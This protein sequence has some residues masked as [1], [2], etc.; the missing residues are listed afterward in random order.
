[1]TT[2][3]WFDEAFEVLTGFS[4]MGW[5]RRLFQ[6]HFL[7]G[8]IPAACDLPTGLGK[9]SVMAIWVLALARQAS[10]SRR[11]GLPRRLVYV[12]N[13]RTVV[14]Q[15]SSEAGALRTALHAPG[16]GGVLGAVRDALISLCV[17][18]EDEASPLAIST[19]RGQLADNAEWRADPARPAIIIGTVD[20]IGSRLLFS[21]YGRGFKSRP[22]HAG[23][24][25]QDALLVHDEAHLEPAFQTLVT[26]VQA[27]QRRCADSRKLRVMALTAT[28]RDSGGVTFGLAAEDFLERTVRERVY[29]RKG[30][31]FH[32]VNNEKAIAATVAKLALG[33]ADGGQ[34]V[35][36]YLRR[37]DDVVAVVE[38]LREEGQQVQALTGTLRGLERDRLAT[39]DAVFAR[40]VPKPNVALASGTVFLV[41]T[42]AGE[43]GAN[44]S[45][46][47]LVCDA[48]TLEA[49]A[50]RFGRVNRFGRGDARIDLVFAES[51]SGAK[52]LED[53]QVAAEES[54]APAED[55]AGRKGKEK[56]P[57]VFDEACTQAVQAL[58]R[59]PKREDGL[60][61]GSPAALLD[62]LK[63]MSPAQRKAAFLPVPVILQATD[64]LFDTWA[65][66]TIRDRLPGRP[67]VADWLHG[68][69][70][71]EP[72]ETYVAWREEVGLITGELLE[73]YQPADL[74]D[75]YPLKPHELLR[76]R[77]DRV[78]EHLEVIAARCPESPVW[79]IDAEDRVTVH[80]LADLAEK[81]KRHR[82][83]IPL[84]NCTV[85]L[86]P[87]SGGLRGGMLRGEATA[88]ECP[89]IDV[90]DALDDPNGRQMRSRVWD[91]TTVPAGMRTVR[92]IDVRRVGDEEMAVAEEGHVRRY[93]RWCVC[94]RA[95]DDDGSQHAR[96]AEELMPHVEAVEHFANLFVEKLGLNEPEASAL[97]VAAH[98]H[99]RGKGRAVWQRS[100][101]NRGYP[102]VVLAKSGQTN[103]TFDVTSYRHE[104][105]SLIDLDLEP[106]FRAL[107]L[108]ATDLVLH[109]IA[110]HHGRARPHFAPNEAFDPERAEAAAASITRE[111][112]RRFA[113]LQGRYG[114]WG[115]AYLESLL[116]AADALA[117]QAGGEDRPGARGKLGTAEEVQ[118]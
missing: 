92:T 45:G 90:A 78:V 103:R 96:E 118:P 68:V 110:A 24:L 37:L 31:K 73:R 46:D 9:T 101:G 48:S 83:Q 116:R 53:R 13:R 71:W 57:L 2:S 62:L 100:I 61:D 18:P 51:R 91:D 1:M 6:D 98:W 23:F 47:H 74:L 36:V 63:S 33:H 30:I 25:G 15:A 66:T 77:T 38:R 65:L 94:P 29:A 107:A 34:A 54:P 80:A 117:S 106:D 79:V 86:S 49:V 87:G 12:V 88:D 99:D 70:E 81:G 32:S 39:E 111:V 114:R 16:L 28:Q 113:R 104:F 60:L 14:D 109:L 72:P 17:D 89:Q 69:A 40:F 84:E 108:E 97:R 76:E 5:Q 102:S 82:R 85:V 55:E 26:A 95:A 27:E 115:L 59:L 7:R 10:A 93:W 19:L 22:L 21:G 11:P 20:M 43:V 67:P 50:Q 56:S 105:G 58:H 64:I 8:D 42:S 41:S 75:D 4:P 44:I 112:P 52:G 35:L 3:A